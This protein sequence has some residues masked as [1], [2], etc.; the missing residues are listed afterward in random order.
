MFRL[1][2]VC[3]L[4]AL[5]CTA[6]AQKKD[7]FSYTWLQVSYIDADDDLVGSGD[8]LG[9][10]ASFE[11]SPNFHIFGGYSG[12][13]IASNADASGW[14]AGIGLNTPLSNLMDVVV[15]L[16]YQSTDRTLPSGI[17]VKDDG[18]GFGAGVRVG[19]NEW[20]EIYGG[21]TYLDVDS[22]NETTFDGGFLLNFGDAFAV[23]VGG[24]WDDEKTAWTIDGRLYFD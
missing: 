22:G 18:L 10:S 21:L 11:L 1:S 6:A 19:A 23:G 4:L 24:S 9:L 17:G 3:V 5:S 12:L 15:R 7:D 8:G 13:D 14:K 2:L 16:S 20:I